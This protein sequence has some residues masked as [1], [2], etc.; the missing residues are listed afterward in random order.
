MPQLSLHSPLGELTLSEEDGAIVALDWGRGADQEA[1]P[2]LKEGR[3]QLHDYFDGKRVSFQLPLAPHGTAFQRRV[4]DALCR[5]PAGETRTYGDIA[6]EVSSAARAVG[7]ANG[8]NPIPI[9]IPCHRVLAS[10]GGIGGYS[11]LNGTVTKLFLLE[12]E[13]RALNRPFTAGG[14]LL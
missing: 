4:W 9:I 11:G 1:T 8:A 6:R 7:Q 12:L 3:D 14:T 2:L 13:A 10:G 5:I